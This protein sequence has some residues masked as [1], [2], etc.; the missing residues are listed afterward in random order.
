MNKNKEYSFLGA[1]T[2]AIKQLK[3]NAN[4]I[5]GLG[6][7]FIILGTLAIIF[8]FIS[9]LLSII[10]LGIFLLTIGTFEGIKAFKVNQWSI[11]FLHLFLSILYVVGGIFIIFYPTINAISLTLLLAIFFVVSGI[12]KMIF[13]LT[14]QSHNRFWLFING[15]I[16]LL[17]GILLWQQW[18]TSGLWVLGTFLG[19]E[20]LFT[21]WTW[22]M[23]ALNAKNIKS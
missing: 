9:T 4:W 10:Y 7:S 1:D 19:I 3:K 2:N 5:L 13:A 16:G 15:A 18:P 14:K 22:V 12:L 23:L 6:I 20:M 17:L 11:L 21:G 8:S